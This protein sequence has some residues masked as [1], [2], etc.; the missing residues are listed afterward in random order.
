MVHASMRR[1]IGKFAIALAC[2]LLVAGCQEV[3]AR[4]MIQEGNKLYR[5]N[6]YAAAITKY[7]AALKLA[8]QLETGWYNL[9]LSHLGLF[10]AGVKTPENEAHALAAIGALNKFLELVPGDTDACEPKTKSDKKEPEELQKRKPSCA[11][12][13]LLSTFIDSGHYEMA[14]EYFEKQLQGDPKNIIAISQIA[15]IYADAG[16]FDEAVSWYKRLA[17]AEDRPDEKANAWQA[18]GVMNWRRLYQHN[19]VAGD[20]RLKLADDGIAALQQAEKH[21]PN[22]VDTY[23][24]TNLLYRQRSLGHDV[25]YARVV[26]TVTAEHY[27]KRALELRQAAQPAKAAA[28]NK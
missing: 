10:Q 13:F 23:A 24:Y 4:R 11:R 18:I 3:K 28:P 21:R 25:S 27:L 16:K 7:E 2:L 14:I 5:D 9:A 1:S 17:D 20:E 22:F 8:P 15:R 26:D 12:N 6:K 19:E